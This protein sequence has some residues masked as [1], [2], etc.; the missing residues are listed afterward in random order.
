MNTT[1]TYGV[2]YAYPSSDT[3]RKLGRGST[4]TWYVQIDKGVHRMPT[5]TLAAEYVQA[6]IDSGGVRHPYC[7]TTTPAWETIIE[8]ERR[9]Q[10]EILRAQLAKPFTREEMEYEDR[11]Y[12]MS[13]N[14]VAGIG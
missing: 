8:N 13:R 7:Q 1:H 14:I 2:G 9:I 5:A 4:G 11:N 6:G 3:A 12:N 10:A